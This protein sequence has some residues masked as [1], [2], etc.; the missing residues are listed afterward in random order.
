MAWEEGIIRAEGENSSGP[1]HVAAAEDVFLEKDM[2]PGVDFAGQDDDRLV[3][4]AER[5]PVGDVAQE[6][7]PELVHGQVLD[8]ILGMDDDGDAVQGDDILWG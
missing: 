4:A 1:L 5:L 6:D 2:R 7:L 8:R 3:G